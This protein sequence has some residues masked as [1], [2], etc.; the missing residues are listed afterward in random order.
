MKMEI[1]LMTQL[2]SLMF[3]FLREQKQT[4]WVNNLD[5]NVILA[6]LRFHGRNKILG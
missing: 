1:T 6:R 2:T 3:T 5:S 4:A